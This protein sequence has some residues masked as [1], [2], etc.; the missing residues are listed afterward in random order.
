[1]N[2]RVGGGAEKRKEVKMGT[3]VQESGERGIKWKAL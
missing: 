1:M 2:G 3:A